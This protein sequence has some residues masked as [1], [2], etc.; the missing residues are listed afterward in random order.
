MKKK[1]KK[2]KKSLISTLAMLVD[3]YG[4]KFKGNYV[5]GRI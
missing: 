3:L 1:K 5:Q 4:G 2:K